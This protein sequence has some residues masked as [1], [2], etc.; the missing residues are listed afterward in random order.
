MQKTLH[1]HYTLV[2]MLI[3]QSV[4]ASDEDDWT[5]API[6]AV[7]SS[8]QPVVVHT[9][10]PESC[11]RFTKNAA[12]TV[13]I[14]PCSP[15]VAIKAENKDADEW[16]YFH[17]HVMNNPADVGKKIVQHF[18]PSTSNI[19][20]NIDLTIFTRSDPSTHT[21][22]FKEGT[23]KKRISHLIKNISEHSMLKNQTIYFNVTEN[24]LAS[25]QRYRGDLVFRSDQDID[26]NRGD[27]YSDRTIL[28]AGNK[29]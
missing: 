9:F 1:K 15:C 17:H 27:G 2:L 20:P 21:W 10:I 6:P 7:L 12:E 5:S 19:K 26:K 11:Y 16:L 14:G 8:D 18:T 24:P 13:G 3:I 28:F 25:G 29:P 22:E 23:H 4:A